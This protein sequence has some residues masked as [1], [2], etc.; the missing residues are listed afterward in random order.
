MLAEREQAKSEIK[1]WRRRKM[2]NRRV[3]RLQRR[4]KAEGK[5]H[6]CAKPCEIRPHTGK[7]YSYCKAC[8]EKVKAAY[9]RKK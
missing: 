7:P 8:R 5:C 1:K 9:Q 2:E 6:Q 4:L 3:R